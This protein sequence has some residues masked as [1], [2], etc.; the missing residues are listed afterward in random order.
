M[1]KTSEDVKKYVKYMR[2]P[3]SVFISMREFSRI[4]KCVAYHPEIEKKIK[5]QHKA[6]SDDYQTFNLQCTVQTFP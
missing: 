2:Q 3:Q 1:E 4:F 6:G 5:A